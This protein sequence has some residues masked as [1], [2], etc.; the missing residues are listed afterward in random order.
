MTIA[1][2]AWNRGI[3]DLP[4]P[5]A[6]RRYAAYGVFLSFAFLLVLAAEAGAQTA[7][8]TDTAQATDPAANQAVQ[9][10]SPPG[11]AVP[12]A[13][14]A[15]PPRSCDVSLRCLPSNFLKDQ[16]AIWTSPIHVK[17]RD[18]KV[19]V[20][21]L[22]ATGAAIATDHRTMRDVVSH[23]ATFNNDNTNASNILIGPYIAAPVILYGVGHFRDDEHAR[24]TGLLGSE[25]LLDGVVVE[26][27]M[28][29]I[30]WR[31]RPYQDR[32]RGRFFQSG[33][34]VDSS[35]PSSHSV[36]AWAAASVIGSEY[37]NPWTEVL[38]YSGAAGIS[39]TR[40]LGQQH[41]P[42]DILVGSAAGWLVGHSVYKHRHRW[43]ASHRY[44]S[45]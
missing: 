38:V 22:L 7:G 25:A 16:E 20:P 26:Q 33:A 8:V 40:L 30:F 27:G 9:P 2:R 21:L 36:L 29:L 4:M 44:S 18:L 24:E 6:L 41:F 14:Q 32:Q 35:F 31:E 23:D 15:Q 28:K 11:A 1:L 10:A 39:L 13:P 5:S 17:P 34:G 43:E 37:R 12:D 42:S 3:I 45:R 19:V